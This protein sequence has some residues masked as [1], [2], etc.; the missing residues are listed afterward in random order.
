MLGLLSIGGV[1]WDRSQDALG[2]PVTVTLCLH[3]KI[4]LFKEV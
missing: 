1:I 2:M 3:L 4:A